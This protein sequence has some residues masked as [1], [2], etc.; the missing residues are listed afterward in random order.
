MALPQFDNTIKGDI[1]GFITSAYGHTYRAAYLFLGVTDAKR[2]RAWLGAI[3]PQV[4]TAVSWRN[5][6]DAPKAYPDTM[7]NIAFT[8]AGLAAIGLSDLALRSFPA[9]LQEGI[10]DP[11]RALRLG[12]TEESHPDHWDIGGTNTPTL[13]ILLILHADTTPDSDDG[14]RALV[15]QQKDLIDTQ[16]GIEI[17]HEEYAYRRDDD[18]ELFG[19]K[20]GIG[21]PKIIG[22]NVRD[23]DGAEYE[24]NLV[25]TG[26]MILGYPS[27]YDL[28]PTA[29]V[30]PAE[31]DPDDILPA[32]TTPHGTYPTYRDKTLKDLGKHGTYIVYRKMY[33]DVATFW[34]WILREVRR[35]D[36]QVTAARVIWLASKFVG[37]KPNGDP[38]LP[39]ADQLKTQDDF[40]FARRDPD[41][42]S[43]PFGS[44]IRRMNPRDV[45]H[46]T[47][48]DT[49]LAT[50]AKHRI[51][52]RGRL[53]GEPLFDIAL[54]DDLRDE[55]L[56]TLQALE[57]D[58]ADRGLH[59]LSVNANIERQ[60]EFI[61]DTWANNPN[62]NA[63]YENRDPIIGDNDRSNQASS[64]MLIPQEP[65]R[66]R[67][68]ALPRFVHVKGGAY[69]F[70]PGITA[71][72]YLAQ[73][74]D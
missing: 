33:Q 22:I 16:G 35:L 45:L 31:D 18:K 41:G 34:E 32:L 54:L 6:P 55:H 66:I 43:C 52:R 1:Q 3:V 4:Q 37:R 38:M 5:L 50:T 67:T 23:Q 49:S 26:E 47:D 65:A 11:T 57:D 39:D 14:I 36:G 60:F 72:R 61:H 68:K 48:P 19:F 73:L 51:L 8:Y 9:Q 56:A 69:C 71:L 27:Q 58:G 30:V 17:L 63:L 10:T 64:H 44:H 70:M 20:D 46:P 29:P 42:M 74:P 25:N 28:Y 59:F 40:L 2:A 24:G 53:Y 7:L 21:Q 15:E 62:F 12:D 13:H